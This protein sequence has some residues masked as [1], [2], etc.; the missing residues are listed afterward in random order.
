MLVIFGDPDIG[1]LFSGYL[2]LYLIGIASMAIGIFASTV[3]SNQII[4]AVLAG[5][6]LFAFWFIGTAAD[7]LPESMGQFVGA[8]SLSTYYSDF[9]TGIIDTRGIVFY[10][11]IS[12][13]FLFLSIRSLENSRWN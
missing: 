12:V 10:L 11:S 2:G 3:T 6:I 1:P 5:V 8:L 13:L 4:A 7:F 9:I